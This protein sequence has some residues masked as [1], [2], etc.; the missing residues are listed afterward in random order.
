MATEINTNGVG[1]DRLHLWWELSYAQYLTVPRSVMQSMPD[2][3]QDKM[4]AL[5]NELDE[6]I[7]WRPKG[8]CYK[9]ELRKYGYEFDPEQDMDVFTW[10]EEIH[11]PL[12]EYDRGR[13]RLPLNPQNSV[14]P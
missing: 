8:A 6:R 4:A 5:L 3:W 13:R 11:D 12:A 2:D 10:R 9:V 14:T 1:A 7:E